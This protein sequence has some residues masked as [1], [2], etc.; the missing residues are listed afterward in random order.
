MANGYFKKMVDQAL[1][2]YESCT[3]EE[4]RRQVMLALTEVE[5]DTRHEAAELA[6][7]LSADIHNI[8][9]KG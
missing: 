6:H 8:K 4:L 2:E 9:H 7:R 3:P 1:Y 5:R